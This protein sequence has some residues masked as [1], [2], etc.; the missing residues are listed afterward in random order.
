MCVNIDFIFRQFSHHIADKN[1]IPITSC[2][3]FSEQINLIVWSNYSFRLVKSSPWSF[4]HTRLVPDL[5]LTSLTKVLY[6]EG[7]LIFFFG[8]NKPRLIWPHRHE[9]YFT[10]LFKWN[11]YK[12]NKSQ[13][14]LLTLCTFHECS[15][16]FHIDSS[17]K[18]SYVI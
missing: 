15:V 4:G 18:I 9:T 3:W 14:V 11:S 16:Y 10:F 2:T 8:G 5:Y 7:I 13:H 12:S 1:S 17:F 6:S